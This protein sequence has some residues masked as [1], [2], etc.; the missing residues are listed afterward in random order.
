MEVEGSFYAFERTYANE[1]HRSVTRTLKSAVT[2]HAVEERNCSI[3]AAVSGDMKLSFLEPSRLSVG[4]I[5][6]K[7][8]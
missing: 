2:P 3:R 1:H 5:L 6:N 4:R 7:S 8:G